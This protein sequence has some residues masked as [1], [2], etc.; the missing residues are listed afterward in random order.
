MAKRRRLEAPS[1]DDL[2]RFEE[3]FRSETSPRPSA[4]IAQVAAESALQSSSEAADVRAG[5]AKDS[6]DAARLRKA[7]AAGLVLVE[8]PLDQIHADAMI[9]DR[10][11]LNESEMLELKISIRANGLRLPIEVFRLPE[12]SDQPFGLLSGYRRLLAVRGLADLNPGKYDTIKAVVRDQGGVDA[13]YT[14]MVEEN[15]VRAPLTHYERGR[16]A[17]IAAQQG[18]FAHTEEAVEKLFG[19]GSKAKRSKVRS[20]AAVFEELGDMLVHPESLTERRGLQIAAALRFGAE[21]K[22]RQILSD[23][24]P[25]TAEEE[26]TL[27]AQV[28]DGLEDQ[29]RNVR[30]GGRPKI[31]VPRAGWSG[32]DTLHTSTGVTMR[33]EQDQEGFVL[34]LKGRMLDQSTMESVMTELARL[35]EKS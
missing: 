23:N 29:P 25:A 33:V 15:E 22:F 28:I 17:V 35:L 6:A 2:N 31:N 16:I 9:R 30:R 18:A 21:P 26:W 4:P 14:A 20:F 10:S 3:E 8:I 27:L 19:S 1:A 11:V 32:N 12:G 5:R 34:R 13:A 7:E 24:D